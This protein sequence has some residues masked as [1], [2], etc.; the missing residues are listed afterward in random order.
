MCDKALAIRNFLLVSKKD[1]LL[2]SSW[3]TTSKHTY[4]SNTHSAK[5]ILF[6]AQLHGVNTPH[7]PN[8]SKNLKLL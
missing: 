2:T 1:M 6:Y 5:F 7:L 8:S 4:K 3:L